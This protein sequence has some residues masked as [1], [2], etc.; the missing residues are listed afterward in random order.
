MGHILLGWPGPIVPERRTRLE[1]AEALVE[2]QVSGPAPSTRRQVGGWREQSKQWRDVGHEQGAGRRGGAAQ[3]RSD[4]N[5]AVAP[6][7]SFDVVGRWL[8]GSGSPRL[9]RLQSPASLR[10]PIVRARACS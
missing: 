3:R 1:E 8:V 10:R 6:R 5:E 4:T 2:G 9:R 7:L